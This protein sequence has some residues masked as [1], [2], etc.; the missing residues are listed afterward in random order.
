MENNLTITEILE[1]YIQAGVDVFSAEEPFGLELFN[2]NAVEQTSQN[3]IRAVSRQAVTD[4][5]QSMQGAQECMKNLCLRSKSLDQLANEIEEFEGCS[6]KLTAK[7]TVFGTGSQNAKVMLIGEAPGADEDRQGVPFVGKCGK[8]LDLSLQALGFKR[9][10]CFITNILPWRPPG[11]RN[12]TDAEVALCLPFVKKQIDLVGPDCIIMLGAV[13]TNA[14]MESN[15]PISK[16]R[17]RWLNYVAE[18]GKNINVMPTFHPSYLLR[19][20]LAKAKFWSDMLKVKTK[21]AGN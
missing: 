21:L 7:N 15:D 20:P 9:E 2:T 12:P 1:S 16:I 6:L 19:N 8:L 3:V 4:L 13:A 17:G 5:S 11:N 10:D 14:I 18:N